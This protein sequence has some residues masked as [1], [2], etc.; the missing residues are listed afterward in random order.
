MTLPVVFRL[1]RSRQALVALALSVIASTAPS[2]SAQS[3]KSSEYSAE[4]LVIEK[5]DTTYTYNADG[6]GEKTSTLRIRL[7]S[8]AGTRQFS[9][10]AVPFASSTEKP[11]IEKLTVLHADGSN[12][13]TPPSDAIEMPAPV[14][15]QAPLKPSAFAA[16]WAP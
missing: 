12:T 13:E 8:E 4:S 2:V 15:Q 9:V 16:S 3:A 7:Q 1:L 5:A 6:T 14:T 10:I 11:S